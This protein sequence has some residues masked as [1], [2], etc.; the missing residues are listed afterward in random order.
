MDTALNPLDGARIS[1]RVFGDEANPQAIVLVHGTALSQAIW[2]GFGWVRDL[3]DE[4][5]VIT[6]DLRG[7]GHSDKPHDED[8]YDLPYFLADVLAVLDAAQ[9]E[10]AHFIG[11]SL[12]ARVGFTLAAQHPTRI[13]SLITLGGS[14]R[15]GKG[16]F[17]R[18]FFPGCIG[19]L[20]TQGMP[21]FIEGWVER[22]GFELDQ[23]TRVALLANDAVALAAYMRKVELDK[24]VPDAVLSQ[25]TTP[26][27]MIAGTEDYYR[28]RAAA[29]VQSTLP[30]TPVRLLDGATHGRTPRHPEALPAVR[31]FLAKHP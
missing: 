24:G 23:S 13:T 12:G 26:L 15:T 4:Y 10:H 27:F 14:P 22:L 17:D 6:L 18:T 16:V 25:L 21:G 2:R 11:Y 5:K 20:E 8:A 29:K 7:H 1:Y 19:V 30:D 3:Q 9:A 28:V 31:W